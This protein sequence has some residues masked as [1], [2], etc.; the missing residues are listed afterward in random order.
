[1]VKRVL[2]ND[3]YVVSEPDRNVRR[4]ESVWAADK[5][6]GIGGGASDTSD[7]EDDGDNDDGGLDQ[8]VFF[9]LPDAATSRR[10]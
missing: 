10:R 1:V 4:Y 9:Q 2:P 7:S 8:E 5:I 6:K 3:R